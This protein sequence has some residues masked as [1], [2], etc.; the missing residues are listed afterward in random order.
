MVGD[1]SGGPADVAILVMICD[2]L[3][4]AVGT[5]LV[6]LRNLT[7]GA[8]SIFSCCCWGLAPRDALFVLDGYLVIWG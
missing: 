1:V 4:A 2:A 5:W 7:G 3:Y 6:T 8:C